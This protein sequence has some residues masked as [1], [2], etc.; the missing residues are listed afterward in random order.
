MHFEFPYVRFSWKED[1][2]DLKRK[3]DEE[4]LRVRFAM[5]CILVKKENLPM[6]CVIT[7]QNGAENKK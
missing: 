2:Q 4:M 5:L 6:W 1:G 7:K 3:S